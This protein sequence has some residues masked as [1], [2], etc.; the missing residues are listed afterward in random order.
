MGVGV[1]VGVRL[2][3]KNTEIHLLNEYD[4]TPKTHKILSVSV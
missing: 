4:F 2:F 3:L 1:G